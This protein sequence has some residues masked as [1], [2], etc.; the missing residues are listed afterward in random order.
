MASLPSA[1]VSVS[2]EAGALAGGTGYC[3][4]MGCVGTSDDITP[5]VFSSAKSLIA[6]HGYA[7]AVDYA[8]LHLEATKKP[9]IFIGLPI[10]T[11][12]AVGRQDA[13]GVTGSSVITIAS[14]ASGYLEEVD[15][16]LT[17][18]NGGTIG[19]NGI[20]FNLSLD[21]GFTEKLIR[22]GTAASYTVPYVGIVIN[23]AAGTLIA[24][25]EYTFT[26]TAP[27]WDSA[28]IAAARTA[29]ASQQKLARSWM[30]IGDIA[31]STFAGYITTAVNAYET[32]N[33]RFTLA[34][35]NVRDRLPLAEMSRVTVRMTGTPTITFAE[36][37]AGSDTITRSDGS[38]ITDGF[39]IGD[40]IT[41]S[42]AVASSGANNVTAAVT[43]VSAL[44]LTLGS[45]TADDL[46]SEG[47][48]SG[49]SI[50]GSHALTFT[51]TTATRTGGSWLADGFR[52]GDSVT[53]DNTA[54]NDITVTIT[55]LSAT[56]MTFASGGAAEVIGTR[57]ATCVK[58]E[59][60]AA[61]VSAMDAA[62]ATVDAQKRI[63]IGLGRL[64]KLS[65]ITNWEFRRPVA[66]AAS[67]REYTK[68]IHVTNWRVKDGPLDG[69][70]MIDED[71][72]V[73]EYDERTDG[74]ALAGRFTCATTLDNGPNGAF[75]ATSLTRDTEGS[76]LSYT[77]NMYVANVCCTVVQAA[78]T[79][80]IGQTP[81]LNDDGTMRSDARGRLESSVNTDL[82]AALLREFVPGEG[83][84]ASKAVWTMSTD[85]VL[86]V[87]G[88][89]VT[90]VAELH[91]NG[92]IVNVNTVV[93]VS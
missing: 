1:T 51:T 65:P 23:F 31:N 74:G 71:G 26:T 22:L 89:T 84:R 58:G 29:L 80:F 53:F 35:I 93:K 14:G 56:V 37:G 47:P 78:T 83:A 70:K 16:I 75:I 90:G 63:D 3:V 32:S 27:M 4:V 87:V 50:V 43:G 46:V 25:D 10:V 36:V 81:P 17:V 77:H 79:N 33:K 52:I 72:N 49:V 54:S 11:D 34:R 5:R 15:A 61:W 41:V 6:Q 38:F 18:V 64:R 91:V 55:N 59:T 57:T 69:W 40:I 8:A 30:P 60:M 92:T 28:G 67:I 86:N 82:E 76:L 21:G 2:A 7:P 66:W 12:G 88:A 48:I 42:D 24:G 73:V 13:S 68:D 44:V 9:V 20:T 85:D 62:F 39:A 19:T 45:A